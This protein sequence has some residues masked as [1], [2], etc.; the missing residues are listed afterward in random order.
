[1]TL[2][3][4]LSCSENSL[5]G[6]GDNASD[7]TGASFDSDADTDAD[8]DADADA[9]TPPEEEDDFLKL[10][11]A[12]TDAYVFV[13][14][15]ARDTVTRIAVPS[16]AVDT[17][18]VGDNPTA[19]LTTADYLRAVTFNEASD[20]V[21]IIDAISFETTTVA[22]RDNFNTMS[23]SP[24][25][26]W[27]MAWYDQDID[28]ASSSGG[29]QSFNEVSFVNLETA[30][31]T[32][33]AVGF[34]PHGVRWT[35][36]G[37][38]ALVVS[39]A[40]LAVVNLTAGTLSPTL[41][42]LADDPLA[43]PPAE[44]VEL[45]NDGAYA[46]VRQFGT[47]EILVV[48]LANLDVTAVSVGLNPTDLDL[49]PDGADIAVVARG[50]RALYVLSSANPFETATVVPFPSDNAYGSVLYAGAGEKALLYTNA[51]NIAKYG[52]WETGAGTIL[53]RSLVK[54]VASMGV[55]PTGGSLL[56]FHTKGDVDDADTSDPF[57]NEWALT[58]ID[59]DDYR[60]NPMLL[61][62]EPTGYATSDD[63]TYGFFMMEGQPYLETLLLDQLLYEEIELKS[64]PAYVGVLPET[65]IAYASQVH[66]L[67]RISFYDADA[68]TLDTVTGFE[69]NADIDHEDF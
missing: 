16:L 34:N 13:A 54:P 51:D 63:G 59:L 29:V 7:D 15:P 18:T 66:D 46:F 61:P 30:A 41:I 67:G 10:A 26:K 45:S 17:T 56:V 68:Q 43:A 31:H 62:A 39:D 42:E 8:S 2:L 9:D 55:S 53:E 6:K 44:E 32:P 5:S 19:V 11:P 3:L 21:T 48:D 14:N 23:M 1:M 60:Q 28:S 69:L 27:I 4:L 22:V 33:M 37:A 65:N 57:Y 35:P 64:L 52:I 40:A 47:D 20:D 24:D 50:S 25:G 49:S 12:A 58:L 38:R 36:D